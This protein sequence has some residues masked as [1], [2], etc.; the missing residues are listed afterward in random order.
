MRVSIN[1]DQYTASHLS[2][3]AG[4]GSWFF[5]KHKSLDFDQHKEGSDYIQTRGFYS[6][7]KGEAEAWAKGQK[8]STIYVQP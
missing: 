3:P 2:R 8:L 5:S 7:V 6:K 1:T 4:M